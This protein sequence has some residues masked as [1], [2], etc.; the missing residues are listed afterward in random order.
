[1]PQKY[2]RDPYV[3]DWSLMVLTKCCLECY[4]AIGTTGGEPLIQITQ[5]DIQNRAENK[6]IPQFS[7][8]TLHAEYIKSISDIL[9]HINTHYSGEKKVPWKTINLD[10][11]DPYDIIR[12]IVLL[13]EIML[14]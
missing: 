8:Y 9:D 5:E 6:D 12:N 14:L 3:I 4:N 2:E 1:M 11:Y 13:K 7:R 10:V